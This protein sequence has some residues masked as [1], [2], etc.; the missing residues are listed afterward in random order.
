MAEDRRLA[1]N[2]GDD[3]LIEAIDEA[4]AWLDKLKIAI[5]SPEFEVGVRA[6]VE[7]Y[8]AGAT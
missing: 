1:K 7:E 3:I 8:I 4:R 5:K 6:W 2:E